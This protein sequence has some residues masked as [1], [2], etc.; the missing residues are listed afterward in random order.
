MQFLK[1]E[2]TPGEMQDERSINPDELDD[3]LKLFGVD[4]GP[5]E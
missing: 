4:E 5:K 3:W 1:R 2:Q